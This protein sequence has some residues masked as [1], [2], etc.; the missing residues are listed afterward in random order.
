M[1][2]EWQALQGVYAAGCGEGKITKQN[3]YL[4]IA[5]LYITIV[6]G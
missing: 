5:R 1:G 2:P 6:A 4:N 3:R